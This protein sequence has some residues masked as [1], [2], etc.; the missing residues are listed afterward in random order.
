MIGPKTLARGLA[1]ACALLLAGCD[2]NYTKGELGVAEFAWAEDGF[3]SCLFGCNANEAVATGSVATLEVKNAS[4]LPSFR[5][6]S[7]DPTILTVAG[8]SR[9]RVTAIRAGSARIRLVA[10]GSGDLVDTLVIR[11]ADVA[12]VEPDEEIVIAVGGG[13]DRELE[14]H[15]EF[16]NRLVGVGA[17]SFAPSPSLD[18]GQLGIHDGCEDIEYAECVRLTA[19][20]VGVG[21]LEIQAVT[22][23][24]DT[25]PL[26]LV[27]ETAI[28]AIELR[29]D[30]ATGRVA[31]HRTAYSD[32]RLVYG[33]PCTWSLTNASNTLFIGDAQRDK[34]VVGSVF[35]VGGSGTVQCQIG[36]VSETIDVDL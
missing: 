26:D 17:L 28:T 14:V 13:L 31:V 23:A 29:R 22:G 3:L 6:S 36:A 19:R 7:D 25:I 32:G 20:D 1:L 35:N 30:P 2:D 34:A 4:S 16:G 11:V 12:A 27:D 8:A 18:M 10:K 9:I 24:V 21:M 15:D 33:A 5:V